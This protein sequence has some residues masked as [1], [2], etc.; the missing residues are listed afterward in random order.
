MNINITDSNKGSNKGSSGQLVNYLE[1]ENSL[2]NNKGSA[3]ELSQYLEKENQGKAPHEK[4]WFFSHDSDKVGAHQVVEALD[5][6]KAKL[7]KKDAK[8][9]LVNISPSQ[10]ELAWIGHD[11]QKLKTYARKVMDAYARNFNR[12]I[13][14]EDLMYFGKIEYERRYK[15]TDPLVQQR[16]VKSGEL[17]PGDQRH[18]HIVVS[19][20]DRYN[21]K[22][23]SPLSNHIHTKSGPIKGGFN[24]K[25][26]YMEAERQFD[27]L[28]DYPRTPEETFLYRNTMKH[29][30]EKEK[31]EMKAGLKA[32]QA[33]RSKKMQSLQQ[34]TANTVRVLRSFSRAF[35]YLDHAPYDPDL[36][37]KRKRAQEQSM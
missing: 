20:K 34:G 15:G 11:P 18:I 30:T 1:K 24:R 14:G 17:K 12:D 5:N 9:Y 32:W 3:A 27:K 23:F 10:K 6:N 22:Q 8:F 2:R 29:G 36:Q 4:E 35:S 13:R 25:A 26:F 7:K 31:F 28:F 33:Q 19:R 16:K 21:Q 37:K